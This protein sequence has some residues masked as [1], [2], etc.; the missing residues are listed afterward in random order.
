MHWEFNRWKYG[1]GGDLPPYVE[2]VAA[3]GVPGLERRYAG[4]DI[5]YLVGAND[6]DPNH[7]F[8]D[9]S[10]AGEAQGPTRLARTQFFFQEMQQR[11]FIGCE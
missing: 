5:V 10:C 11:D 8:L 6:N 7:R 2:A 3:L 9:K 1:F 4:R